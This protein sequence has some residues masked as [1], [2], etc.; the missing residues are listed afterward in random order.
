MVATLG[1]LAQAAT[2]DFLDLL[3]EVEVDAGRIVDPARGIGHGDDGGAELGGLLAGVD[4]DVA[5]TGQAYRLALVGIVVA[6]E[7]LL[8]EVHGA[9]TRCLG[10]G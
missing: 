7:V 1:V 5:G 3:D 6:V 10:A 4:G 2:L 8:G 9:V